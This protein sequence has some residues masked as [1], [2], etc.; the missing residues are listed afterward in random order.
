M[1]YGLWCMVYG[2]WF[3]F[4][5]LGLRV[6][7]DQT[8][9]TGCQDCTVQGAWVRDEC[10]RR[11]LEVGLMDLGCEV[12]ADLAECIYLLILGSQLPHNIVNLKF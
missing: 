3:M 12:R 6:A 7:T 8:C 10:V 9:R 1:V 2:L 5:G 4:Q 11:N